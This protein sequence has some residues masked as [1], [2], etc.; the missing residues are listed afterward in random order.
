MTLDFDVKGFCQHLKATKP[1]YECPIN[2]CGKVYRSLNGIQFHLYNYDHANPQTTCIG[3]S[4]E[5]NR[6]KSW[7]HRQN[8]RSPTPPKFFRPPAADTAISYAQAQKMVE[9][10]MDGLVHRINIC[11]P[12]PVLSEEGLEK[13]VSSCQDENQNEAK[14]GKHCDVNIKATESGC[15]GK[16]E[17]CCR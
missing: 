8:R 6:R 16:S 7:H 5:K 2:G 3:N 14:T 17:K 1:P 13:L 9:V 4:P 11:D 10:D 15:N 12:L